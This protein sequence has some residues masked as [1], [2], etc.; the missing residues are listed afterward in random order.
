MVQYYCDS[1][2]KEAILQVLL[3]LT[4]NQRNDFKCVMTLECARLLELHSSIS[5]AS[6]MS[7]HA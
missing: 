4:G 7:H 1:G 5:V 2:N 3:S 6:E